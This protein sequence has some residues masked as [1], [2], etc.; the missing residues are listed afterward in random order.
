M[1]KIQR[2]IFNPVSQAWGRQTETHPSWR[3]SHQA[4]AKPQP[5]TSTHNIHKRAVESRNDSI[6]SNHLRCFEAMLRFCFKSS[7]RRFG[8][9][10]K[11]LRERTSKNSKILTDTSSRSNL[12]KSNAETKNFWKERSFSIGK[13]D[14]TQTQE[15]CHRLSS[16]APELNP[17]ELLWQILV[18]DFHSQA[19]LLQKHGQ[20]A[21]AKKAARV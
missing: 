19:S 12:Q 17:I 16:W 7:Q 14:E 11:K 9:C 5:A 10:R 1:W 13:S 2:L 18:N 8:T 20:H 4:S 6:A 15:K 3:R 21:V